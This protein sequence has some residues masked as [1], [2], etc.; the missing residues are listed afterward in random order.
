MMTITIHSPLQVANRRLKN[1]LVALPVFTGYAFPDGRVSPKL[2][3]HYRRLADAGAAMV[4]V[5]NVAVHPGGT[6]SRHNL[7][8]DRDDH[9][10]GLQRLAAAIQSGGAHACIQLNHAGR[11]AK[12]AHPHLASP[13]NASHLA[14]NIAAMKNFMHAFP[15][16]KRFGLTH[17]FLKQFN[18]WRRGMSTPQIEACIADFRSAARRAR[19]AGFDMIELHGANGYLLCEFLSPAAN[20]RSSGYGGSFANRT[21]FPLAVVRAIRSLRPDNFPLGYRLLLEEWV[22][23]GIDL[24]DAV[25]FARLLE[26]EGVCYLSA[27]AGTFN[28]IFTTQ[29]IRKMRR[30]AYLREASARLTRSVQIPTII[31]GRV[32]HPALANELLQNG[33]ADLVGLGRP[34]RVD[35]DWI[36]KSLAPQTRIRTCINCNSC[37]KRVVLE[38]GF[39]CRRW[40]VAR[41]LRTDLDL[42]LL[43][44]DYRA[45]WVIADQEDHCRFEAAL[46]L[47]LAAG[48]WGS[49]RWPGLTLLFMDGANHSTDPALSRQE[50]I[51]KVRARVRVANGDPRSVQRMDTTLAVNQDRFVRREIQ[52]GHY[53]QVLIG[54][55]PAEPW[56]AR[57]LYSEGRKVVGLV[58]AHPQPNRLA[59]FLDLSA[60]SLLLLALLRQEFSAPTEVKLHLIH[61]LTGSRQSAVHRWRQ[62]RRIVG[63]E[64]D[65]A[66]RTIPAHGDVAAA[67]LAEAQT[68]GCGSIVMGKRGLSGIKRLLLGSISRAV[69]RNLEGRSLLLVD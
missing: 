22:P 18:S 45:L 26:D 44:R 60:T 43:S 49:R 66:L 53:G 21:A 28:S 31:A 57:L 12:T 65:V 64:A 41:Q 5:A 48:R 68:S 42:K 1:R 23:G 52:A 47:L 56:R 16:E 29:A 17:S 36:R 27:A 46:P 33:V 24:E 40:P 4:V 59:V 50:L 39:N 30:P 34:L 6:T 35:N 67:L 61:A 25:A 55:N 20:R 32:I 14:Y 51:R 13:V 11:F 3:R 37:I 2:I 19:E 10:P 54:F 69:L 9:I 62:Y 15:L 58:G 63:L 38:Q 8:I 7:R